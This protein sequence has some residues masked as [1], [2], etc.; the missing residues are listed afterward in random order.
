M[1]LLVQFRDDQSGWHELKCVYDSIGVAYSQ[2]KIA[3]ILSPFV[4]QKSLRE[5]FQRADK[6]ILG[7]AG[8][9]GWEV[10]ETGDKKVIREFKLIL[11]KITHPLRKLIKEDKKPVLGICF[12]HQLLAHTLGCQ[13]SVDK[14]Q[15]ETGI[16]KIK[17]S[18]LGVKNPLFKGINSPFKA[19]LGHKSS[20]TKTVNDPKFKILASSKQCLVEAFQYGK[21]IYGVQFHPEL[22]YDD[23]IFRLSLYPNY[24]QGKKISRQRVAI[25]QVLRN[26]FFFNLE[27]GEGG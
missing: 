22:D 23:M 15:A 4:T 3:N 1:I 6:I 20:V 5:D 26:F 27:G 7:G 25:K 21:N 9:H 2:Y 12:G 14:K 11:D 17:L 16:Y 13:V 24:G 18:A 8:K 10:Y 19:I